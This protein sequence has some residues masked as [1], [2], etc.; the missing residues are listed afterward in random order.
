VHHQVIDTIKDGTAVFAYYPDR[1]WLRRSSFL[2]C[3]RQV[4][5]R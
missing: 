3:K 2:Q 4:V 5:R 1:N